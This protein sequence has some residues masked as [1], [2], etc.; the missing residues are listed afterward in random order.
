MDDNPYTPGIIEDKPK[1]RASRRWLGAGLISL[2]LAGLCLMATVMGMI[3]SFNSVARA[4]SSP[5]A[6]ELA[7][8][9]SNSLIPL[10]GAI[11]LTV[12]GVGTVNRGRPSPRTYRRCG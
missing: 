11:P 4:P 9:I 3:R 10:I 2:A 12:L 7:T 1:P 6:A 8:G 5:K